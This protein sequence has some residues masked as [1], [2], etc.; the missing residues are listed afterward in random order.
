MPPFD[1]DA[2]RAEFPALAREQDG[3]PVVFLDGPGGTQVPQRVIDAVVGYYRDIERQLGR[4][5]HDQRGVR[6]DRRGGARRRRR[7]PGG[8]RPGRDQVR[9]EHVEPDAPPR[10]VD[11]R[12]PRAGRRDRRDDARPRGE[13]QHLAGDGR[14]PRR[15]GPA[16]S[17]STR[18]RDPRPRGP[19]VEA[20]RADEARRGGLRQQ[21]GRHGQPGPRDRRARPRGRGADLRRRGGV[22]RRTARSTSAALDTDFLACSAYKWF[23][24]HLGVLYGKADA[25]R[26]ACRSSRS[27]RRTTAGRPGPQSFEVDRRDAGR[28]RLPARHRARATATWRV[29]RAPRTGSERRR[30]LVAGMVA[31]AAYERDLVGP[32]DRRP[33]GA[34]RA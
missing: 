26:S 18:R 19:R 24:P 5:V 6:R 16:P 22:S 14:R 25:P 8:G 17:T 12:D 2:L 10:A 30:E 33:R 7:L 27:G 15:D 9:P 21:R 34:S 29:R 23:G 28:D 20:R 31:I 1:V 4:G 32:P 11:R 3:R 13:R